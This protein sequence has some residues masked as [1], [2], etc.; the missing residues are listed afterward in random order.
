MR[1]TIVLL[2][3]LAVSAGGCA[4][5]E[6]NENSARLVATYATLKVI[7]GDSER[8]DRVEAIALEVSALAGDNPEATVDTLILRARALI[9]WPSL[10]AA[11]QLLV[12][13]LLLELSVRLKEVLGDGVIPERARVTVQTVAGWII[14]AAQQVPDN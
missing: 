14:A 3:A 7:D 4:F 5:I 8:A 6:D 12:N 11:D 1:K 10:D 2:A 9:D 13:A